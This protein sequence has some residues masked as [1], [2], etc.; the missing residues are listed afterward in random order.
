MKVV[1]LVMPLFT[2]KVLHASD[3]NL[4]DLLLI[5]STKVAHD[6]QRFLIVV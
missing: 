2:Q 6:T 3:Q 4:A 5:M 1:T